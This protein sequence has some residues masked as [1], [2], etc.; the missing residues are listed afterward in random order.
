MT[1][2]QRTEA[3]RRRFGVASHA[4][5]FRTPVALHGGYFVRRHV[6]TS[7]SA[8]RGRPAERFLQRVGGAGPARAVEYAKR[9]KVF[10][11]CARPVYRAIGDED[12]RNRRP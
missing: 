12:N 6:E 9:T 4:A 11:L 3:L 5:A 7:S 10:H 1:S 2:P 8:R